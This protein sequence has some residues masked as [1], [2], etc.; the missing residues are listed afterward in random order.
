M[1]HAKMTLLQTV[2]ILHRPSSSRAI[3]GWGSF[4]LDASL[5]QNPLTPKWSYCDIIF[6]S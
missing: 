3:P 1:L 6:S 4:S 5:L 2:G